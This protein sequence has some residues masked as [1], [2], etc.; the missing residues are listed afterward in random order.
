MPRSLNAL[1]EDDTS[2]S[3]TFGFQVEHVWRR[4]CRYEANGRQTSSHLSGSFEVNLLIQ[5]VQILLQIL[6]FASVIATGLMMWKGLGLVTNTESPIVVVLRCIVFARGQ[7]SSH[8]LKGVVRLSHL[9]WVYG[10]S[11]LPR[12]PSLLGES[13][14]HT[15]HGW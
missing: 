2:L 15:L 10:A 9:Q 12:R 14:K 6:Q 3:F 4:T 8:N 1:W 11:I 7:T 5:P 13:Q